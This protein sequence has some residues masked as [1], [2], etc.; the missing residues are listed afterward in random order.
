MFMA[1]ETRKTSKGNRY[2]ILQDSPSTFHISVQKDN[3]VIYDFLDSPPSLEA[4]HEYIT[5]LETEL[6][7]KIHTAP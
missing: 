3:Y 2:S 1:K 5:Q 6:E 4:I 7:G